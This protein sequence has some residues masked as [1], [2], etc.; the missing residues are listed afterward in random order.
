MAHAA[1]GE[2]RTSRIVERG[3][4]AAMGAGAM[5]IV[6]VLS[7]VEAGP[8]GSAL[9]LVFLVLLLGALVGFHAFQR[10]AYGRFGT[11]GF[12]TTVFGVTAQAIAAAGIVLGTEALQPLD[13]VGSLAVLVGFVAYGVATYRAGRLPRWCGVAIPGAFVGWILLAVSL[14]DLGSVLGGVFL[15]LIWIALGYTLRSRAVADTLDRESP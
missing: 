7:P 4:L 8:V 5:A 3:G 14:G 11:F 2:L 10:D 15:G 13:D 12:S 1:V 6:E 9:F